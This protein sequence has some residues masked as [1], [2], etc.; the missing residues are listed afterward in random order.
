[1]SL[2]TTRTGP[3]TRR[4]TA[5]DRP[6]RATAGKAAADAVEA[7]VATVIVTASDRH[8]TKEKAAAA[9]VA[10]VIAPPVTRIV[11]AARSAARNPARVAIAPQSKKRQQA[12]DGG[13]KFNM[14]NRNCTSNVS[15]SSIRQQSKRPAACTGGADEFECR[16]AAELQI[17]RGANAYADCLK[18]EHKYTWTRKFNLINANWA[19]DRTC[20]SSRL[21]A[22]RALQLHS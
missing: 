10:V 14:S 8:A 16:P 17:S 20:S 9:V 1:M 18:L 3:R 15:S 6:P 11:A 4:R 2:R 22:P 21:L 5:I 19:L 12:S 7:A 13:H